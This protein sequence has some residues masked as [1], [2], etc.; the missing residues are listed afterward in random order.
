MSKS[1][2]PECRTTN[3]PGLYEYHAAGLAASD[4]GV[5]YSRYRLNGKRTSRSLETSI[6]EHAWSK[7]AK[8]MINVEK[9]RQRGA[10]SG[11]AHNI[12][13]GTNCRVFHTSPKLVLALIRSAKGTSGSVAESDTVAIFG[14]RHADALGER[15]CKCS[16]AMVSH[17]GGDNLEFVI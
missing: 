1:T 4:R 16:C 8:L 2:K 6:F 9:D 13:S 14:R 12:D 17:L 11:Y 7:H 15:S 10:V 3:V 5:Y